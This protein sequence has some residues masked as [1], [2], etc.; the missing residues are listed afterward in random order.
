LIFTINQ[1]RKIL[2]LDF[3]VSAEIAL[4]YFI[5][6][7]TEDELVIQ[8]LSEKIKTYTNFRHIALAC[9]AIIASKT[10]E[11]IKKS[12]S[13][14]ILKMSHSEN[15]DEANIARNILTKLKEIYSID[16]TL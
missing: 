7:R 15:E 6:Q 1:H 2:E 4:S 3:E 9:M 16:L 5:G 12:A 10:T 11:N 8:K 13:E 14:K